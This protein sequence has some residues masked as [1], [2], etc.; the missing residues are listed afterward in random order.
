EHA[1]PRQGF[2]RDWNTLIYN[3][4]RREVVNYL[5]GN[6]LFWLDRYHIDGLRVDAVAS[7]LYLD[8]SRPPGA[9]VPNIHG[10]RENLDAI[11][12]L[13]PTN[14]AVFARYPRVTTVAEE[15]TAWPGVS[16]PIDGG[17]LGFG[18]KWNMGWMHDTLRY[19]SQDPIHR[20]WHHDDLTF[21]M[22]YA[23]SEN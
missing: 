15:S 1:D 22:L 5:L 13:K 4:G 7:M 16:R 20:R 12:F 14:E 17:G 23:Y 2:H 21:G 11:S 9:W 19:M 3:Y 8:Y 18:Y 10:R 6:A